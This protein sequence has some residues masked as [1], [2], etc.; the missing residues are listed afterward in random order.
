MKCTTCKIFKDLSNYTKNKRQC[1]LCR[2]KSHKAWCI[3]NR[4]S[5][6]LRKKKYRQDNKEKVALYG[7][8]FKSEHKELYNFYSRLRVY[9][10]TSA[11]GSHTVQEWNELKKL[12]NYMCLSCKKIEP[13]VKLCEDHIVPLS[14][15][16]NNFISNIQ[17]LCRPCNTSKMVKT[18]D[19]RIEFRCPVRS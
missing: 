7:K 18:I 17:P 19:Y 3:K 10:K 14:K 15:G 6:L 4:D 16:G 11:E 5:N 9:R 2:A 13:E 1:K 12:Y 8:K